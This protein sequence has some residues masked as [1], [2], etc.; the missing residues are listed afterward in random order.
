MINISV[1]TRSNVVSLII[2]D[3]HAGELLQISG[4]YSMDFFLQAK[5]VSSVTGTFNWYSLEAENATPCTYHIFNITYCYSDL[6][7]VQWLPCDEIS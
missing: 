4:R 6:R 5:I 2:G 1:G 3:Q 7:L